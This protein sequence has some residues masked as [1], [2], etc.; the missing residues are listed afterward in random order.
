[1]FLC[2]LRKDPI[3]IYLFLFYLNKKNDFFVYFNNV[4]D[5][6]FMLSSFFFKILLK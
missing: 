5:K 4:I 3:L 2:N 6:I 1:M